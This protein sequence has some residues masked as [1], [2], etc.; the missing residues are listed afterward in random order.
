MRESDIVV[1]KAVRM[2]LYGLFCVFLQACSVTDLEQWPQ[3]LPAAQNFVNAWEA[4]ESNQQFQDQGVYLYWVK[5]FY[6]G[7]IAYPTGWS[8]V[9][10]IILSE[11]GELLDPEFSTKLYQLGIVIGSEWAKENTIRKIDN[12]LL[13]MW[14]SVLQLALGENQ[15]HLAVSQVSQDIDQLLV[16]SIEA[17]ALTEARYEELLGI[18]L[19]EGF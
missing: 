10:Q 15:H 18:Q 13:S 1:N 3:D 12:R 11:T 6:Q 8:D 4:D 19:F 9:E 7:N 2:A 16:G 5:A 14:A 17:S